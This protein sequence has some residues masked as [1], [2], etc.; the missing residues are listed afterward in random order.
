METLFGSTLSKKKKQ[1][2]KSLYESVRFLNVYF[3]ERPFL[4][5]I[6]EGF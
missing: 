2:R 4:K 1:S 6:V 5:F 3:E